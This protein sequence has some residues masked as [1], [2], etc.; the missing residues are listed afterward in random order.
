MKIKSIN[1]ELCG[2]N[3]IAMTTDPKLSGQVFEKFRQMLETDEQLG[4]YHPAFVRDGILIF[5]PSTFPPGFRENVERLLSSA[6]S[7]L[8]H[9]DVMRLQKSD[10]ERTTKEQAIQA[11]AK[12]LGVPIE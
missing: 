4:H 6:E 8:K 5:S 1:R 7:F 2:E 3:S 9:A 10:R 11:A 12:A